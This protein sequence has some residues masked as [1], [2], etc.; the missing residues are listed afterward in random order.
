MAI[1]YR[2]SWLFHS[3]MTFAYLTHRRERFQAL[4][5]WV[6]EGAHVLDV[7]CGDGSFTEY[8][9]SS[10]RY[11]GLDYSPAFVRAARRR[12]RQVELF[13]LRHGSLP[14]SQIIV[15]QISLYQFYPEQAAVL[16]RLFEAAEQRLIVSESVKS[17]AKSR[18][19]WIASVGDWGLRVEGM[20]DSRFRFSPEDLEKLFH[21]YSAH[22]HQAGPICGGRDWLYVLDK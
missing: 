6:P 15:C 20:I 21:P 16:A 12:G 11:K 4:A 22:I 14:A 8:L 13:D 5:C 10:V 2:H 18:W 3:A 19:P 7:C 9:P 1:L 17:L